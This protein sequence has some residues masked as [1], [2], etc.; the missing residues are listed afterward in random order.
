[1][2]LYIDGY[3][4]SGKDYSY[5]EPKKNEDEEV[6]FFE[7]MT[8]LVIVTSI[9]GLFYTYDN[10]DET[11]KLYNQAPIMCKHEIITDYAYSDTYNEVN[12]ATK[13]FDYDDCRLNKHSFWVKDWFSDKYE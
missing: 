8:F 3:C 12:T 13:T 5:H 2:A 1:M 10:I 11:S 4:G 9:V 7:F 6:T